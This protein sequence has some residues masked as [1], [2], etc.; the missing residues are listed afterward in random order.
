MLVTKSPPE[1]TATTG[2]ELLLRLAGPRQDTTARPATRPG[3]SPRR[4]PKP[5]PAA[6]GKRRQISAWHRMVAALVVLTLV[7]VASAA[8]EIGLHGLSFF[9]FRN[10]G[11]G[12]GNARNF[13]ENQGP[14]QADAP[15][16]HHQA[17]HARPGGPAGPSK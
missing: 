15:G 8:T 10:T 14:G 1:R 16:T 13:E 17:R 6:A 12:A 9:V 7:G 5:K 4:A 2:H 3:V 11:A